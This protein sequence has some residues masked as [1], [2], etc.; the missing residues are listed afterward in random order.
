[1]D[2]RSTVEISKFLDEEASDPATPLLSAGV[3]VGSWV[4]LAY[5]GGGGFGEVYRVRHKEVGIVCALKILKCTDAASKARFAREATIIARQGG[6]GFPRFYELGEFEQRPYFIMEMLEAKELPSRDCDIAT[7]LHKLCRA[8]GLL[9]AQGFVHRDIKPSNILFRDNGYPVLVDYGL[10]KEIQ[11]KGTVENFSG[12]ITKESVAVGTGRYVAPE[13]L[14]GET[15][16]V[17]ADIHSLGVLIDACFRGALPRRWRGIV[18]RATS[19]LPEH[20]FESVESLDRAVRRRFKDLGFF[21]AFVI[22]I[23]TALIIGVSQY[24]INHIDIVEEHQT[25]KDKILPIKRNSS[26][27]A[28]DWL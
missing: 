2:L 4:I 21:V 8:V 24:R 6:P 5:L 13:Q 9:H 11:R 23:V 17:A 28:S 22:L 26:D 19:S 7:F 18:H 16:E 10:V 25:D 1:M 14:A 27:A 3:A 20:R 15:I 12:D